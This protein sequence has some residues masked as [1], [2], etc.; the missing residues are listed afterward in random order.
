MTDKEKF[1]GLYYDV[2][3]MLLD[4]KDYVNRDHG[5]DLLREWDKI[6]D[7]YDFE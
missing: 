2:T 7:K 6:R 5:K 1:Q 4:F 3:I